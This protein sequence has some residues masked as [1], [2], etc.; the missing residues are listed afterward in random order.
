MRETAYKVLIVSSQEN[1]LESI[2][3]LSNDDRLYPI[4]S[5][6]SLSQARRLM[7]ENDFD[8]CIIN[9]P[10]SDGLGIDF[11]IDSIHNKNIG[12][13]MLTKPEL[14]DEIYDK[15]YEYGVL[16]LPKP[17]TGPVYRQ[18]LKLI[19]SSMER[20]SRIE[21]TKSKKTLEERFEEI[22]IINNAKLLLIEYKKITEDEAHRYLEK[23]A[24]D[25]RRSKVDVARDVIDEYHKKEVNHG[26]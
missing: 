6:Q 24:M 17:V 13:I 14:Y 21:E 18:T 25:F 1:V 16:L 3:R 12:I 15:T 23:R 22:K 8:I 20:I 26:N 11:A 9:S 4:M 19:L 10:L 2:R 5:A 7:I